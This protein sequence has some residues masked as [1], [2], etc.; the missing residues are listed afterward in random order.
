M[1]KQRVQIVRIDKTMRGW[2]TE[3]AG[4]PILSFDFL[5]HKSLSLTGKQ[6]RWNGE[7]IFIRNKKL[8]KK[9]PFFVENK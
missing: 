2:E 6:I 7:E 8:L 9:N 5:F 3:I 1:W 4:F